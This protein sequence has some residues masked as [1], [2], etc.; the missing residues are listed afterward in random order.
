MPASPFTKPTVDGSPNNKL[1]GLGAEGFTLPPTFNKDT[2][3]YDLIVDHSV[4]NVTIGAS[5]IDSKASVRGT[6]NIQLQSGNN[7]ISVVVR[8]ENG[9]ERTYMIHVVRQNNG[10]TYNAALGG[11]VSTGGTSSPDGTTV[12][13]DGPGANASGPGISSSGPGISNPSGNSGAGS[14]PGTSATPGAGGSSG[15][16]TAPGGNNVTFVS[17]GG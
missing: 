5:A 2:T 1:N 17:P 11:G 8:A 6:G 13:I 7:E 4:S 9:T 10:P 14:N 15:T 3:S 12:T 16:G